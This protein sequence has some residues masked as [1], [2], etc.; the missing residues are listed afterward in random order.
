[1]SAHLVF[2][3]T[4]QIGTGKSIVGSILRELGARVIDSDVSIRVL[5]E[6]DAAVRRQVQDAFPA[7]RAPDGDI[8][9][10]ALARVVF[11]DQEQLERLQRLL[12]PALGKVA[13]FP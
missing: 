11:G 4:G 7:A 13:P 2:G 8:D 3:L 1:M 5:L 9:R 12:Y 10:G 6:S